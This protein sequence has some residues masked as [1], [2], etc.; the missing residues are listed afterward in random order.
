LHINTGLQHTQKEDNFAHLEKK[1]QK[2]L[3]LKTLFL[4]PGAAVLPL[5]L[6]EPQPPT[7]EIV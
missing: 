7:E 1:T 6:K 3:T 4:S 5:K 2:T